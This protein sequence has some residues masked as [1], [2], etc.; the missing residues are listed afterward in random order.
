MKRRAKYILAALVIFVVA[1]VAI[2]IGVVGA[3]QSQTPADRDANPGQV[4]A[5]LRR[6]GIR[7]AAKLKKHYVD[8]FDPNWDLVQ[9]DVEGLT[10]S[11]LAIVTGTPMTSSTQLS[12]DGQL[13][14][15]NY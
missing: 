14:I 11:S 5:A 13:V 3:R 9:L 12:K 15:T 7:E 4:K 6:G 1:T 8:T 10:K 2:S